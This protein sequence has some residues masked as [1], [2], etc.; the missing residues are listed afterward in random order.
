M[1]SVNKKAKEPFIRV[2]KRAERSKMEIMRLRIIAFILALA[3]GGL[4][5]L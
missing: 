2:I 1:N 3:A 5:I 4:F